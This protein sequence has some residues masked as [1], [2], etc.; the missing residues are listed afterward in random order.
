[1]RCCDSVYI[2]G[3]T[4]Y[5]F[6]AEKPYVVLISGH[7][8]TPICLICPSSKT[9]LYF[10]RGLKLPAIAP[11]FSAHLAHYLFRTLGFAEKYNAFAASPERIATD[12]PPSK[13]TLKISGA[14]NFANHIRNFY[15]GLQR[16]IEYGNISNVEAY[17]FTGPAFFGELHDIF[18][19]LKPL[20][21][22]KTVDGNGVDPS[23]FDRSKLVVP[24]GGAFT[25]EGLV[26]RVRKNC[27]RI[28]GDTPAE[29]RIIERIRASAINI[30]FCIRVAD[31]SWLEQES[32]IAEI[33]SS[34]HAD[35]PL[36]NFILDGFSLPH[37]KTTVEGRWQ[38]AFEKISVTCQNIVSA[39]PPTASIVNLV[40]LSLPLAISAAQYTHLYV[41]PLGTSHHKVAWFS[42]AE[43]IIY[44]PQSAKGKSVYGLQGTWDSEISRLPDL[45][46]ATADHAGER[47]GLSD[48]RAIVDNMS[49]DPLEIEHWLRSKLS[50]V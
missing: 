3:A 20:N 12:A 16:A 9:V 11:R 21:W 47:F 41:S 29:H 25:S 30:W 39:C 50:I 17:S 5:L 42:S 13:I 6:P 45:I 15:S 24:L 33:I 34:L 49:L 1:T 23:P 48:H 36:A 14:P 40:G 38:G 22:I 19:E 18:P 27:N 2:T 46:F 37:G 43:G 32:G 26:R 35:Y 31:K 8:E 44:L 4:T 10:A 7:S 28:V